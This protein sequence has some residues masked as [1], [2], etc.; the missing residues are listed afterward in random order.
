MESRLQSLIIYINIQFAEKKFEL[1]YRANKKHVARVHKDDDVDRSIVSK[2]V[3]N[4]TYI[5]PGDNL[6]PPYGTPTERHHLR[7]EARLEDAYRR[8]NLQDKT[9]IL[10]DSQNTEEC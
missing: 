1:R 9:N 2:R 10:A 4:K 3:K 6:L 8:Q 5:C 7:R